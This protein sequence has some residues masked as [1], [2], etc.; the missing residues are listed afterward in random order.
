MHYVGT[1]TPTSVTITT[2]NNITTVSQELVAG[3]STTTTKVYLFATYTT[4][5]ALVDKIN[6]DGFFECKVLDTLRSYPTATQFVDGLITAG[7]LDGLPVWDVLVDTSAAKYF[8]VCLTPDVSRGFWGLTRGHRVHI[9]EVKYFA[10][11]GGAAANAF[12]IVE[13]VY[14]PG[15]TV[16]A[17]NGY[18]T[19]VYSATS[20]SAAATTINWASGN[21]EITGKDQAELVA[22]LTDTVSLAD[23]A[24]NFLYVAGILE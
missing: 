6:S 7:S 21:G 24:A 16:G 1:V 12:K 9:Q 4:V 2:G 17:G 10:T 15:P 5:G 8:A 3:V 11:L 14:T 13:R 20:V 19:V 22:V 18:E 23:A